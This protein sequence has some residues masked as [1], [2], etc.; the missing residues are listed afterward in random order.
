M[1][2]P[3]DQGNVIVQLHN[4][5]DRPALVQ[6]W[7]DAGNV[8][9]T[10]ENSRAPFVVLPPIA[11]V[12]PSAGQALRIRFTGRPGALPA[13]RESLFWLN[14]LDIPPKAAP[15]GP[16]AN[17][18]YLQFAV[19]TR[20]KLFYRPAG[21]DGKAS[22]AP[23]QL[24]WSW[25]RG[26]DGTP[27]LVA[28]N[29]TAYHVTLTGL[30]LAG[31]DR[32]LIAQSRMLAPGETHRWPVTGDDATRQKRLSITAINDYGA[33]QTYESTVSKRDD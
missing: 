3:A 28:R 23:G 17:R 25:Q 33:T 8:Q 11:R 16:T 20:I 31:S 9:S 19:R 30:M 2:Y 4:Q 24:V 27:R 15:D 14:V 21:L 5:G 7:V 6:N 29:P 32:D 22:D 13:D 10:P 18:N 12:D 26:A 1:V